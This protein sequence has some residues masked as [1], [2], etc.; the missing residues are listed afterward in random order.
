MWIVMD[1]AQDEDSS[2]SYK[3]R[4]HPPLKYVAPSWSWASRMDNVRISF[5]TK[6]PRPHPEKKPSRHFS[7]FEIVAAECKIDGMNNLGQVCGGFLRIRGQLQRAGISQR[8]K[9]DS[10]R[11]WRGLVKLDDGSNLVVGRVFLDDQQVEPGDGVFETTSA[12]TVS[13]LPVLIKRRWPTPVNHLIREYNSMV[14]NG[15]SNVERILTPLNHIETKGQVFHCPAVT[16]TGIDQEE[17]RHVRLA[18][19]WDEYWLRHGLEKEIVVV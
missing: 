3:R 4:I 12:G 16:P 17:Y 8:V 9:R 1:I 11:C 7:P 19:I 10:W 5:I 14:N 15:R 18:E 13:C 2:R 6:K